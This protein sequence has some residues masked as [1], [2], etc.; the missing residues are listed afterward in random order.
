[1]INE[2]M[3][4]SYARRFSELVIKNG[5]DITWR[6]FIKIEGGKFDKD[7]LRKM[8]AAGCRRITI[9][10]ESLNDEALKV[11]NKGYCRRE[12][13]EFLNVLKEFDFEVVINLIIDAP[14][15]KW[16][17]AIE[18]LDFFTS[19]AKDM[20]F[21]FNFFH[22][23][24]TK[25]SKIGC[26]PE[27]FGLKTEKD[28]SKSSCR[29]IFDNILEYTFPGMLNKKQLEIIE[30]GYSG[31]N[32]VP[33]LLSIYKDKYPEI[34]RIFDN[35]QSSNDYK[36]S[37]NHHI[38]TALIEKNFNFNKLSVLFVYGSN[39]LLKNTPEI[40]SILKVLNRSEAPLTMD[41]LITKCEKYYFTNRENWIK[42][43]KMLFNY[44]IIIFKKNH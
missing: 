36:I 23:D 12:A 28:A 30:A 32:R 41:N 17:D 38:K 14:P 5:L 13:I 18:Q 33:R 1:M 34:M 22:F 31:L 40:S 15:I 6:T 19:Y 39:S 21:Y 26:S 25:T 43:I 29:S 20:K 9:G 4:P 35:E 8:Y 27:Q 44:E 7:C 10:L 24:L 42:A 37:L 2:S 16:N 11:L 3:T